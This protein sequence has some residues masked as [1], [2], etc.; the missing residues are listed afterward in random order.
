MSSSKES[1]MLL[2]FLDRNLRVKHFAGQMVLLVF[3]LGVIAG[4]VFGVVVGSYW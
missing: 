1:Q 2:A 3:S 4:F